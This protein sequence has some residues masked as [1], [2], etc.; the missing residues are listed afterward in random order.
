[1]RYLVATGGAPHSII[2]VT[3]AGHL[4]MTSQMPLTLL[5]VIKREN[6]RPHARVILDRARVVLDPMRVDFDVVIRVG[7]P[8]EEILAEAESG[9]YSLVVVGEKQHHRFRTRFLIGSTALRV[10][11]HAPCPAVIVKG[12]IGPVRKLLLCESGLGE[13]PLLDRITAQLPQLLNGVDSITVLHVMSQIGA[14]PSVPGR[15]LGAVDV[16]ELVAEHLP[17]GELLMHDVEVLAQGGYSAE[18]KIR[19][20]PVVDEILAEAREGNYGLV[21]IGAH[22]GK[23]WRRILLDD[24]AHQILTGLDRPVL[25]VR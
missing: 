2:A 6:E 12:Q 7:H 10:V 22:R 9:R 16:D 18:A 13:E 20:G 25:V 24:I 23:G 8:A 4:A 21:A 14:T 3:F 1:M 15:E 19:Y 17:P 5:A 11:E